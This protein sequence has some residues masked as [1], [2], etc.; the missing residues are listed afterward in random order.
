M[1]KSLVNGT[2]INGSLINEI[3]SGGEKNFEILQDIIKSYI[4][5]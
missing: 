3:E 5:N 4:E 1:N 2:V